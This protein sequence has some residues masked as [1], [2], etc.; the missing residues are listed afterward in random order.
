MLPLRD[1][2]AVG[3]GQRVKEVGRSASGLALL[4]PLALFLRLFSSSQRLCL[5]HLLCDASCS[6]G[7]ERALDIMFVEG[8]QA[9]YGDK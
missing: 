4:R 6:K 5:A 2:K 8:S 1:S 7:V 3:N 9:H